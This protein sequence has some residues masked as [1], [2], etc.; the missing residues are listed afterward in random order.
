MQSQR[1]PRNPDIALYD[2]NELGRDLFIADLHGNFACLQAAIEKMAH[3]DRL[4]LGGDLVDRGRKNLEIIN[5]I[6]RYS[7]RIIAVRGNHEQMCLD[8]IAQLELLGRDALK[9]AGSGVDNLNKMAQADRIVGLHIHPNNGGQ[10]LLDLYLSEVQSRRIKLNGNDIEYA[11]DSNIRRI[12]E[13]FQ[14]LPYIIHVKGGEGE[15][16]FNVVHAGMPF[17]DTE[18]HRKLIQHI[19]LTPEEKQ[20]ALWAGIGREIALK[21][22]G[23]GSLSAVTYCGHSIVLSEKIQC[24]RNTNEIDSDVGSY[25]TNVAL[26]I[27]HTKKKAK[28]IGPGAKNPDKRYQADLKEILDVIRD[29]L[30]FLLVNEDN[31]LVP[32]DSCDNLSDLIQV[33]RESKSADFYK[34]IEY[35]LNND[36]L[37]KFNIES[38]ADFHQRWFEEIRA[39]LKDC[40][41]IEEVDQ[42]VRKLAEDWPEH[43]VSYEDLVTNVVQS[44]ALSKFK[45][46]S[47][48]DYARLAKVSSLFSRVS[49]QDKPSDDQ[50][51]QTAPAPP[52]AQQQK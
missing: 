17:D 22:T 51:A 28:Y 34:F 1:Q 48:S 47:V 29:H 46:E 43:R 25:F 36:A 21:D 49:L 45:V 44:H 52:Q 13:F 37:E 10:W 40:A 27:N 50:T 23:R 7:D 38:V 14:Q 39:D 4:F 18:L 11:Y 24:V 42:R 15:G 8:T 3:H 26:L 5:T 16:A 20:Y 19:G 41:T 35:Y 9:Q 2:H 12:K 30:K 31:A 6:M 33:L 32:L